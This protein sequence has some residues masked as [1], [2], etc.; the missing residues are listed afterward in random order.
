MKQRGQVQQQ[1]KQ[2]K[3]RARKALLEQKLRREPGNCGFFQ[4][5]AVKDGTK[6]GLC[7]YSAIMSDPTWE[8]VSCNT[9][10][11]KNCPQFTAEATSEELKA[12][13]DRF[14]S[15]AETGDRHAMGSLAYLYPDLAALLWVMEPWGSDSEAEEKGFC[16]N[17]SLCEPVLPQEA[18]PVEHVEHVL[19]PKQETPAV[20]IQTEVAPGLPTW[21]YDPGAPVLDDSGKSALGSWLSRVGFGSELPLSVLSLRLGWLALIVFIIVFISSKVFSCIPY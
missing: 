7:G 20:K 10:Q 16:N 3:Y 1:Y 14:V 11:A 6:V 4:H 21:K 5:A 19:A 9:E 18:T 15:A 17:C 13:F 2:V 8:V 12:R